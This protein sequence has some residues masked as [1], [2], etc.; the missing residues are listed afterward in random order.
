MLTCA[1]YNVLRCCGRWRNALRHVAGGPYLVTELSIDLERLL[2][3]LNGFDFDGNDDDRFDS[4]DIIVPNTSPP[5]P[6]M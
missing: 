1:W 5:P 4:G 6:V 2:D 3:T